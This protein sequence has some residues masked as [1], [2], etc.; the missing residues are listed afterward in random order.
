MKT[1]GTLLLEP[2]HS[3]THC[4][5]PAVDDYE[6]DVCEILYRVLRRGMTFVDCGANIGYFSILANDLVGP[7]GSVVSIE[8]NPVTYELLQRN[9]KRNGHGQ[10]VHLALTSKSGEVE[11]FMPREGDVYS[12]LRT[13]G[14]VSS[15]GM[16]VF[17]IPGR[18]LDDVFSDFGICADVV[19]IDIEGGELDVLRSSKGI[20]E[21]Q[22]PTIIMEYGINTWPVF[23]ATA[24]D[25]LK[26]LSCYGY[27]VRLMDIS[28]GR[29]VKPGAKVWS[30]PYTN[31]LL[32]PE[33]KLPH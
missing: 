2:G 10:A 30:L 14:L 27:T 7:K 3:F 17:R 28:V 19:K 29:F 23:G 8:A 18:K 21:D 22:R 9:L 20:L 26:L 6:P 25:L 4:F 12:S 33:E 15:E 31:L 24:S 11:L 1:G 13:G 5:W 32:F 16:L